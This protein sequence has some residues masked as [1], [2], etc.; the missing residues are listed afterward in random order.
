MAAHVIKNTFVSVKDENG[1]HQ[2]MSNWI[3]GASFRQV[4]GEADA[5]RM[6]HE[7]INR[8]PTLADGSIEIDWQ[9]DFDDSVEAVYKVLNPLYGKVTEVK[10]RPTPDPASASNPE[11]TVEVVINDLPFIDGSV[12]ELSTFSTSWPFTGDVT[13]DP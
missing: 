13:T 7:S 11:K 4:F 9:Q 2:T 6:G 12:G 8:L 3:R 10:V 5:T 1:T